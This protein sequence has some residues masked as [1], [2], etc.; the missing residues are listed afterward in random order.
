MM[1]HEK[2]RALER[3]RH[4]RHTIVRSCKVR[5]RRTLLFSAGKTSDISISGALV[6]VDRIR[7]FAPGDELELVIAWGEDA[8][9]S[10]AG[11]VKARVRRVTPIDHHHQAIAIE[12]DAMA[13]GIFDETIE[14]KTAA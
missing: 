11:I 2:K 9:L 14:A 7:P 6:R 12:F 8:V 10:S 13:A 3:R 5:D 1:T 4:T